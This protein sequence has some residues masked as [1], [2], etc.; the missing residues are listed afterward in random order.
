MHVAAGCCGFFPHKV[1]VEKK[2]QTAQFDHLFDAEIYW[3]VVEEKKR[4]CCVCQYI[5]VLLRVFFY[6]TNI[7]PQSSLKYCETKITKQKRRVWFLGQQPS[8]KGQ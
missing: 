3:V 4:L 1:N 8:T 2:S 6:F 7:P 5:T